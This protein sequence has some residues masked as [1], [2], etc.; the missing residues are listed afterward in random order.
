[1]ASKETYNWK[2]D[3]L[4]EKKLG[5]AEIKPFVCELLSKGNVLIKLV[6]IWLIYQRYVIEECKDTS[7]TTS[8]YS[9]TRMLFRYV[10]SG[11]IDL[12]IK[13]LSSMIKISTRRGN[14]SKI[15]KMIKFLKNDLKLAER[16]DIIGLNKKSKS[17]LMTIPH[18]RLTKDELYSICDIFTKSQLCKIYN[19]ER[20]RF[21]RRIAFIQENE[22]DFYKNMP[23]ETGSPNYSDYSP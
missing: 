15:L 3:P 19:L 22:G 4:Y 20:D 10:R 1:M 9:F 18:K 2:D 13:Q 6:D 11:D 5:K 14:S 17:I 8:A 23:N 7:R 16:T 21:D 12:T